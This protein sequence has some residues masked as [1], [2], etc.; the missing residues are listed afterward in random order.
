MVLPKVCFLTTYVNWFA[1]YSFHS[2]YICVGIL[3]RTHLC[4]AVTLVY[5]LS[6]TPYYLVCGI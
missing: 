3:V 6:D 4:I 1:E 5:C 2:K